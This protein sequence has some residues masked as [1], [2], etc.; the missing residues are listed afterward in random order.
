MEFSDWIML[1]ISLWNKKAKCFLHS[2]L[3]VFVI[4]T[5]CLLK[6]LWAINV[7]NIIIVIFGGKTA[8]GEKNNKQ[9]TCKSLF[10]I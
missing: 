6:I 3:I 8:I 7:G 5:E 9:I 4:Q 2:K 10:N 1:F